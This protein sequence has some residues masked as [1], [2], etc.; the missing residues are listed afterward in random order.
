MTYYYVIIII[1]KEPN[2][3]T[4]SYNELQIPA[5]I[6]W[7]RNLPLMFPNSWKVEMPL[8]H[9]IQDCSPKSLGE[10]TKVELRQTGIL[11]IQFNSTEF[12]T[13]PVMK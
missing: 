1:H 13:T 11:E 12:K 4:L 8:S 2:L 10:F 9:Y 6:R 3:Q 7:Q 5:A